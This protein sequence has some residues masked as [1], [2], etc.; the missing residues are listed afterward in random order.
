[1]SKTVYKL[2]LDIMN[3]EIQ[4]D[5]PHIRET[6]FLAEDTNFSIEQSKII[7][8][9]LLDFVNKVIKNLEND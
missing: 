4:S 9:W 1:M 8:P 6:I 5:M 2:L 7:S 3:P